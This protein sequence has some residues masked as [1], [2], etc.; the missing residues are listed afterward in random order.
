MSK[1]IHGNGNA[2]KTKEA[3]YMPHLVKVLLALKNVL[4]EKMAKI[5][6]QKIGLKCTY[7]TS[8]SY[9][10]MNLAN[11]YRITQDHTHFVL[12]S[13]KFVRS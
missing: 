1:L 3:L 8:K 4:F 7:Q 12:K 13:Y 6:Q 9:K 5:V 10:C 2:T 11:S